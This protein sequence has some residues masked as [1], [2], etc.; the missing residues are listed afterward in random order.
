MESTDQSISAPGGHYSAANPVP[1]INKF[2]ANLDKEKK[3]RDKEIDKISKE[4]KR[5]QKAGQDGDVQ[6]HQETTRVKANQ[7][8]VTDPVTGNQ[9]VIEDVNK[10]MVKQVENPVVRKYFWSLCRQ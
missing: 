6:P 2:I 3:E 8:E 4:K 1:T 7:K 5:A 10:D 9:V